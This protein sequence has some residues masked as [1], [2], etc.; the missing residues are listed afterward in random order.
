MHLQPFTPA[1]DE[2]QDAR[3]HQG[4]ETV[5]QRRFIPTPHLFQGAYRDLSIDCVLDQYTLS[6]K[7]C[8][9]RPHK[10]FMR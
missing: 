1:K 3:H 8:R 2:H 4:I 7:V 5:L 10:T 9:S 6:A